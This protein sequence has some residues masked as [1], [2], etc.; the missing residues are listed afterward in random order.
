MSRSLT[1]FTTLHFLRNFRIIQISLSV[2]LHLIECPA[3]NKHPN[4][5]GLFLC[6]EENE[7]L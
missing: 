2:T 5:L 7:V 4:L 1:L 3:N 6:Y